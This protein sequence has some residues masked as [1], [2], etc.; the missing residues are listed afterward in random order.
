MRVLWLIAIILSSCARQV[1]LTG[2]L[3]DLDPPVLLNSIPEN[4]SLN[5]T[6]DEIILEFDEYIK[7]E[8]LLNQ[9]LITP[10]INGLFKSRINRNRLTL[11]FDEPFDSATTYTFNFREGIKDITESNI[12]KNLRFVFSTGD[13]LDSMSVSGKVQSLMSK[14]AQEEIT[15]SLY[16]IHDSLNVF[17]S[18]PLYSTETLEDG[19]FSI[20]NIKDGTYTLYAFNDQ[21]RNLKLETQDESYSFHP[22]TLILQDTLSGL[23]LELQT[24]DTRPIILQNSRPVGSN[25]DLKFNKYITDYQIL[26]PI[27]ELNS[28]L[29]EEHRTLRIY[30]HPQISDSLRLEVLVRD[31][32]LQ[33]LDTAVY[34][35]FQES[36]RKPEDWTGQL[37]L[38][39][40]P[41]DKTFTTKL[42]FNKPIATLNYDSIYF[43]FDSLGSVPIRSSQL[44]LN[45]SRDQVEFNIKL[46]SVLAA[47]SVLLKWVK[48]F[49]FNIAK[50]AFISV[51]GDTLKTISREL[52]L[53]K[54]EDYGLLAGNITATGP[55]HYTLQLLDDKLEVV[56]EL[57]LEGER[58]SYRFRNLKPGDYSIRIL[59]DENKNGRWDTG[60]LLISQPPEKVLLFFHPNVGTNVITIR[61]NWEQT[62][63][64]FG[65]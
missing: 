17:N 5:F 10:R 12:P 27:S 40:G 58:S 54:T 31:S 46:D 25:Y 21:N 37:L 23:L 59:E 35:K 49:L 20:Q 29:V 62:G 64:D 22:D 6:G 57:V 38:S 8:N 50:G 65:F 60:N 53:K 28:N 16:P 30:N 14:E 51:E 39:D 15:V 63:V 13:Y 9:L 18:E 48:P 45:P 24:V 7:E 19:S 55:S 26:S 2:G 3:K 36:T 56:K 32:L 47:D 4:Q 52:T 33:E 1:P 41:V 44:N 43:H 61:A 42:S 11:T 34:V